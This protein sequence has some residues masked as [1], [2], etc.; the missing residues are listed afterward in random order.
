LEK[1]VEAEISAFQTA[2]PITIDWEATNNIL[3]P[4]EYVEHWRRILWD[5][6]FRVYFDDKSDI[7]FSKGINIMEFEEGPLA[8]KRVAYRYPLLFINCH[9]QF[10]ALL[11][12]LVSHAQFLIFFHRYFS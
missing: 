12:I 9:C 11:C 4:A 3:H 10:S 5:R 8:V 2:F 6:A 7:K 1:A